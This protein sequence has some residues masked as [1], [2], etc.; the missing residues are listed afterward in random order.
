VFVEHV[1]GGS[2]AESGSLHEN[3]D[4]LSSRWPNYH[5]VIQL[6]RR[7]HSLRGIHSRFG[8]ELAVRGRDPEVIRPLFVLHYRTRIGRKGGTEH[9]TEDLVDGAGSRLDPMVL[10]YEDERPV[11]Q[12]DADGSGMSFPAAVDDNDETSLSWVDRILDSGVDLVHVQHPMGVPLGTLEHLQ[13]RAG[14]RGLPVVWSL[15]DYYTTCPCIQL[16]HPDGTECPAP[17]DDCVY[18]QS[19]AQSERGIGLRQWRE[20]FGALIGKADMLVCPTET[21]AEIQSRVLELHATPT[22]IPHGLS[23]ERVSVTPPARSVPRVVVMG[24]NAPQ[25]G[26]EMARELTA[27]TSGKVEWVFLGRDHLDGLRPSRWVRF[28]GTYERDD[29]PG[30]LDRLAPDAI[31]L[32][33]NWHETYLYTLSEAWRS[34]I[35]VFGTDLG[36]MAERI[37]AH[38]GGVLIHPGDSPAAAATIIETLSDAERMDVLRRD[39]HEAGLTLPTVTQMADRYVAMYGDLVG[40]G[41]RS[42]DVT[43]PVPSIDEWA[44]WLGTFPAPFPSKH[45]YPLRVDETVG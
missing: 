43:H 31:A 30:I 12:W 35:P 20:R 11:V 1:G 21:A 19:L 6:Y 41:R 4:T 13:Q 26:G 34:G 17:D 39:A 42:A 33:S 29:L 28:A 15:H 24:Y 23:G 14:E 37:H 8:L 2:F 16:V 44:G 22:V 38:G 9:H 27:L 25:K 5:Q 3:L 18:C 40:S 32:L 7:R 10:T 36:A 45:A